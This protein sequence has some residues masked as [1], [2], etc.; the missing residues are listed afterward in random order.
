VV[1]KA[2]LGLEVGA[3]RF[4]HSLARRFHGASFLVA[5]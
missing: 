4:L 3:R 2:D 1:A 5:G